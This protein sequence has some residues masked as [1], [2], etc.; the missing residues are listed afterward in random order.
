MAQFEEKPN[1]GAMFTREKRTQNSPDFGGDFSLDAD[2]LAH[3][4][5]CAKR[6]EPVKLRVSAWRKQTQNRG[7][8]LTMEISVP[9]EQGAQPPQRSGGAGTYRSGNGGGNSYGSARGGGE[10]YEQPRQ[11]SFDERQPPARYGDD[12]GRG[13]YEDQRQDQRGYDNAPRGQQRGRYD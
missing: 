13:R 5:E 2:V 6:G 7:P 4:V 1:R 9:T 12:D 10:R 11:Q 8:M 3:V